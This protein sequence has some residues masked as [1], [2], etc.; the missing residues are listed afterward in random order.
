MQQVDLLLHP[1]EKY[2]ISKLCK[3]LLLTSSTSGGGGG[4]RE[5]LSIFLSRALILP[6]EVLAFFPME[7]NY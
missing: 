7:A 2:P 1:R 3:L 5:A 6:L 4:G